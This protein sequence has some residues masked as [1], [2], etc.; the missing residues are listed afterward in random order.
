MFSKTTFA[1]IAAISLFAGVSTASAATPSG[2]TVS[3][4]ISY[5]DLDLSTNAGARAMFARITHAAG[6]IC[7]TQ[8]DPQLL[9]A[10]KAY[11]GCMSSV[12]EHAVAKLG[13]ARVSA[14]ASRQPLTTVASN[15]G[16]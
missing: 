13:S 10:Q 11:K 12:T 14:V 2:D 8:P 5:N 9:D 16:R 7:G 4:T 6:E 15:S 3:V 1:A